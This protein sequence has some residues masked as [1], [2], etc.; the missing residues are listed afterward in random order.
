MIKQGKSEKV[1][2]YYEHI[3]Q[4]TNCVHHQTY[5]SLLTTFF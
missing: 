4:L 2:I 1:E 3:L 5:D